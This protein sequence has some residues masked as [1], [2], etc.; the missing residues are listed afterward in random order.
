MLANIDKDFNLL[1]EQCCQYETSITQLQQKIEGNMVHFREAAQSLSAISE[2]FGGG[3]GSSS[4]GGVSADACDYMNATTLIATEA[5]KD[6]EEALQQHVL[7]TM[8]YIAR[9]NRRIEEKMKARWDL[10]KQHDAAFRAIVRAR[11]TTTTPSSSGDNSTITPPQ[12]DPQAATIA[13]LRADFFALQDQIKQELGSLLRERVYLYQKMLAKLSQIQL[14]LF[15]KM[16]NA[17]G[18]SLGYE[19]GVPP[20]PAVSEEGV[21]NSKEEGLGK[22]G[23]KKQEEQQEKEWEDQYKSAGNV[24]AAVMV[25]GADGVLQATAPLVVEAAGECAAEAT[26][27]ENSARAAAVALCE[28]QVIE[29]EV[30]AVAAA[31]A[32]AAVVV[33][34]NSS[35]S[36]AASGRARRLPSL[37]LSAATSPTSGLATVVAAA[38]AA[39]A[40]AAPT[41]TDYVSSLSSP[42]ALLSPV[43]LASCATGAGALAMEEGGGGGGGGRGGGAGAATSKFNLDIFRKLL[44]GPRTRGGGGG[45]GKGGSVGGG[46]GGGGGSSGGAKKE[47]AESVPDDSKEGWLRLEQDFQASLLKA[48]LKASSAGMGRMQQQEQYEREQQ[49]LQQ[50]QQQE[51]ASASTMA[52]GVVFDWMARTDTVAT[53]PESRNGYL[54]SLAHFKA[55][56]L[57]FT[58]VGKALESPP[59]KGGST[60]SSSGSGG[61]PPGVGATQQFVEWSLK[62][63]A[64]RYRLTAQREEMAALQSFLLPLSS[65]T[66]SVLSAGG[67][68]LPL[69]VTPAPVSSSATS[70]SSLSPSSS[71]SSSSSAHWLGASLR[72]L[73]VVGLAQASVVNKEWEHLLMR[74]SRGQEAWKQAVRRGGVPERVRAR[75]WQYLIYSTSIPWRP[76]PNA[77]SSSSSSSSSST[78][79]SSQSK[80]VNSRSRVLSNLAIQASS[81]SAAA[82]TTT[83]SSS[84][85]TMGAGTS[86]GEPASPS[87]SAPTPGLYQSLVARAQE[88]IKHYE[89]T[90]RMLM[91]SSVFGVSLPPEN[92]DL[93]AEWEE[94]QQ[95]SQLQ[96]HG[97]AEGSSIA[98]DSGTSATAAAVP[99]SRLPHQ[100]HHHQPPPRADDFGQRRSCWISEIEVDVKRT[101]V[102]DRGF[103]LRKGLSEGGSSSSTSGSSSTTPNSPSNH[104]QE[105]GQDDIITLREE[106][107]A[108]AAAA[109]AASSTRGGVGLVHQESMTADELRCREVQRGRLSRVLQA[110]AI[111]NPRLRYC[112]GMNMCVAI[113]LKVTGNDEEAAFWLLVGL[114]ERCLME[115][116]WME[117]MP[118]LKACFAV[119]DRL[120]HL[121]TP[122]LHAHFENAGVHVAMFSSKWFV[123]LFSNLDTLPLQT[124]LR[125]WDVFLLEGWSVIFGVAVSLIEMLESQLK[126]LELEDVLRVMQDPRRAL[127][128]LFLTAQ[129]ECCEEQACA[130]EEG[131]GGGAGV[132]REAA[133]TGVEKGEGV[134]AVPSKAAGAS[135]AAT[136]MSAVLMRRGSAIAQGAQAFAEV[137]EEYN[138]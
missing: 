6:F 119:L 125:V 133:G 67:A 134:A 62:R 79:G 18:K 108:A 70:S 77:S 121:R 41:T 100:Q 14:R 45:G 59:L 26:V 126:D 49:H 99:A 7:S 96:L 20:P 88:Q 118:R 25:M 60:S 35:S 83:T 44:P 68:S 40:A 107:A 42:D 85:A 29:E 15:A 111:Y 32:A 106:A 28:Q 136:S 123:T 115:E 16:Y 34:A 17:L 4:G 76:I 91:G 3:L 54:A 90:G 52:G 87:A 97:A 12:Q 138:L 112:Q 74:D 51:Q 103:D 23:E 33:T 57:P 75:L 38:T 93:D 113:L 132:G 31:A 58:L 1:W 37:F 66:S 117:G 81:M 105:S 137:Q 110:F 53:S 78:S 130:D 98:P 50:Q 56:N 43:P 94:E 9:E 13:T 95:R 11:A 72:F 116:M 8:E 92:I 65:S 84:S 2:S 104:H 69:S 122:A 55:F 63:D 47:G 22:G 39:A 124:V 131:D 114:C 82:A 30:A 102:V 120:L 109:A 64:E 127:R 86:E 73:D 27:V 129:V 128:E 21:G 24:V 61:V 89:K 48:A 36:S 46:G 135:G 10:L 5:I 71:T 19:A 80:N 101:Y